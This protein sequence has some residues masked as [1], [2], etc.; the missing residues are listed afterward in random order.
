MTKSL[1][2]LLFICSSSFV[3]AQ[4]MQVQNMATAIRN[5]DYV[6]GK[7]AADAAAVHESTKGRGKMWQYRGDVYRAIYSDTSA[8]VKRLDNE[9]EEKALDAYINCLTLDAKENIYKD[10]VKGALV[11]AAA[12]TSNKANYY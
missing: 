10:A 8:A 5:K 12:A 6:K 7:A 1:L 9:A 2:Q 3:L 4:S 11:V